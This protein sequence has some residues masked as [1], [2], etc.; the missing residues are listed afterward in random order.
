MNKKGF[1]L[2][3]LLVVIALISVLALLVVPNVMK[4][5]NNINERLYSEKLD[6]ILSAAEL[7]ASNNPDLFSEGDSTTVNVAQLIHN[8]Y[9]KADGSGTECTKYYKEPNPES[10]ETEGTIENIISDYISEKGCILDPRFG[11]SLNFIQV[12]VTKK[13]VGIVA[14]I[15][16]RSIAS[17]SSATLVT[18]VCKGIIEGHFLG[19]YDTGNAYCTC[20][21]LGDDKYRLVKGSYDA[22]SNRV[23]ET[24]GDV[25]Q[26]VLVSNKENGDIDNWVKYGATTAN[27][28]VV[29]LYN[30]E[31][32]GTK[33]LVT[34]IITSS[35][36]Q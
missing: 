22:D 36:V 29:G 11:T 33:Q 23:V 14:E 20:H 31:V 9:L 24:S 2:T 12:V 7:Y 5:R 3:E 34:K 26:C 18:Q 30:I 19:K 35:I 13:N 27:W 1:T 6:Y 8:G 15:S 17:A 4:V 21:D 28:R 10:G 25:D 32:D 16:N